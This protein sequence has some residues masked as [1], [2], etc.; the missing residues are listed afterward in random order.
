MDR[1]RT[2]ENSLSAGSFGETGYRG[3]GGVSS[4]VGDSVDNRPWILL[5]E[6]RNVRCIDRLNIGK[7]GSST[8]DTKAAPLA[9]LSCYALL[10]SAALPLVDFYSLGD[11]GAI[12]WKE[13]WHNSQVGLLFDTLGWM[14]LKPSGKGL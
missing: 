13:D 5:L 9:R 14:D 8:P 6:H 3:Q 2:K 1:V 11:E 7:G 4:T 12:C 10:R